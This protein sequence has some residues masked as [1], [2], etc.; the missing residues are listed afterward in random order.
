MPHI[1]G[2]PGQAQAAG[3]QSA[4]ETFVGCVEAQ[5]GEVAARLR[6][7]TVE[8]GAGHRLDIPRDLSAV[9]VVEPQPGE[10]GAAVV[11][12]QGPARLGGGAYGHDGGP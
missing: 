11:V 12:Q 2:S 10:Q 9:V 6:R 1:R 8:V 5:A 4:C 3:H 7:D